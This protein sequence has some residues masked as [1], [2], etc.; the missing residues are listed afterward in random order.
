MKKE[1]E[2]VSEQMRKVGEKV[3]EKRME[4]IRGRE[5]EKKNLRKK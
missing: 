1:E 4:E 2:K 3:N 5:E